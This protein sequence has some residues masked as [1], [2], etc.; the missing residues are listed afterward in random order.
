MTFDTE[1][2]EP[3]SQHAPWADILEE[4]VSYNMTFLNEAGQGMGMMDHWKID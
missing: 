3:I 4:C 2:C 1:G